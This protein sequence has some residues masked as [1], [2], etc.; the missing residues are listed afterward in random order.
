MLSRLRKH[1][2]AVL[3]LAIVTVLTAVNVAP[4]VGQAVTSVTESYPNCPKT[5]VLD[6]GAA[7]CGPCQAAKK[8]IKALEA[9][10][11][12]VIYY[13]ADKK[14]N[15]E[16]FEDFKVGSIPRFVVITDDSPNKVLFDT[17]SVSELKQWLA[18]HRIK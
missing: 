9:D 14:E 2:P 11:W 17:Q 8:T 10:G 16:V 7:W 3:A 13:D 6:F 4:Y 5:H 1:W 12:D 15:K 18:E